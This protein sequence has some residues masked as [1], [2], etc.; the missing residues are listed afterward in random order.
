MERLLSLLSFYDLLGFILPGGLFAA[1]TYWAFAGFP[2]EPG[3]ATTLGLIALFFIAGELVQGAAVVWESRY[4]KRATWPSERLMLERQEGRAVLSDTLKS[5]IEAK[6]AAVYGEAAQH[7]SISSKFAL[8]RADLRARGL[9][10]RSE[11]LNARY[12]MSRGLVTATAG[13]IVAFGVAAATTDDHRRNLVALIVAVAA[14]PFFFNRFR[15][16]A[17]WFARQV[18]QDYAAEGASTVSR[19]E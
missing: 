3:G 4:W 5:M 6:L 11:L 8:A 12:S 1:G 10:G 17:D 18:W 9:D 7:L 13:L 14:W 16:F 19:P 2:D 15:R